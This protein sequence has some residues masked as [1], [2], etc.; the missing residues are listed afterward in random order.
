MYG[1]IQSRKAAVAKNSQ[2]K[3]SELTRTTNTVGPVVIAVEKDFVYADRPEGIIKL[4]DKLDVM[5]EGKKF[6]HP[7]SGKIIEG[8]SESLAS[9]TIVKIFDNYLECEVTPS[10]AIS[11]I[12]PGLLVKKAEI[13]LQVNK[14]SNEKEKNEMSYENMFEQEFLKVLNNERLR[15]GNPDNNKFHY[16]ESIEQDGK[17]VTI[18]TIHT[19]KFTF[20]QIKKEKKKKSEFNQEDIHLLE[21]NT[22]FYLGRKAGYKF[23]IRHYNK[24]KTECVEYK[25]GFHNLE[26]QFI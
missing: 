24:K 18:N 9:L 10:F 26:S 4:G 20:N 3:K 13:S 8:E 19:N 25:Y 6:T 2:A 1:Q 7:I 22:L 14:D 23:I 11:N 17:I 5:G 12:Q 16:R 15:C 21:Q